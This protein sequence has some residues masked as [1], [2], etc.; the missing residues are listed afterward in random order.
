VIKPAQQR[1]ALSIPPRLPERVPDLSPL[2]KA[3]IAAAIRW[4]C[5]EVLR[6]QADLA[7]QGDEESI[8][9]ALQAL[10]N[11]R[12]QG[13]RQAFW[14]DD[15]ETVERSAKQTG[16]AG[17]IN[18]Q[19]DLSFRPMPYVEVTNTTGWGWFVECKI[20]DATHSISDYRDHGVRRFS[21]SEYAAAMGS[22]AMLAYVRDS[23]TPMD[24]LPAVLVGRVGT[25]DVI[26][27]ASDR[28]CSS[29][30]RRVSDPPEVGLFVLTHLWFEFK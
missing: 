8:T 30:H 22:G 10:L 17:Q 13:R 19:P 1:H 23:R 3:A 15:F 12:Q 21:D 11:Q 27:G 9:A 18:K 26:T 29:T 2:H 4:A 14:I 20:L 6:D 7:L 25:V 5:Q 16:A 24:R 28:D